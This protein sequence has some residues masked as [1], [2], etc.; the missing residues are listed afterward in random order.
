MHL[1]RGLRMARSCDIDFS[2]RGLRRHAVSVCK[3]AFVDSVKTNKHIF[4]FF[5][6]PGS[7]TIL[8]FFHT[9]C[10]CNIP[11]GTHLASHA[12][13]VGKNCDF[14]LISGYRSM[15]GGVRTITATVHRAVYHTDRHASV[16]LCLSQP[17]WT[18]TSKRREQNRIICMQQ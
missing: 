11:T 5:S 18:T 12:G 13:K 15:T 17:V 9:K 7:H 1:W 4:K 10:Y 2:S 14:Q 8:V 3:S 6:P 16:N